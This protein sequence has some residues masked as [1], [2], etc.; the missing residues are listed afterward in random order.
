METKLYAKL[1]AIQEHI[2]NF[3]KNK[4]TFNY[5][6]VDGNQVLNEIRP[7]MN[8][9]KLILKQEITSIVNERH[10]YTTKKGE[11][12]NEILSKVMLRFTWICCE[13]GE[14]DINEFGANGMN[15]WDKG[16]GSA[17][18]YGER[19]FLL[20]YFHIPTDG[21][22][23]DELQRKKE[24]KEKK[25]LPP[26]PPKDETVWLTQE[27]FDI[28]IKSDAKAIN[29][30]ITKYSSIPFA[31]KKDFKTQLENKLLELVTK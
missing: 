16:V 12:K 9:N 11:Q 18:T 6:Y 15:D 23:P 13:T 31:M 27:Q 29:A 14:K 7:L 2:D 4:K 17:L 28:A 10:D 22:D 25:K 24:E 5:S 30:V 26:P 3:C 1:H 19:Y 8:A 21:D 20:K